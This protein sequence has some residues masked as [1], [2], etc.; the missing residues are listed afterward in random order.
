[1]SSLSREQ[2]YQVMALADGELEGRERA[3]AELLVASNAE[4]RAVLDEMRSG[5]LAPWLA[6]LHDGEE[7][8]PA[9]GGASLADP[10]MARVG[11]LAP[12]GAP[13]ASLDEARSR[14]APRVVALAFAAVAL[15]AGFAV[16]MRS[17]GG[18]TAPAP[19]ASAP[20]P[21]DTLGASALATMSSVEVNEVDVPSRGVSLFEIPVAGAAPSKR[22]SSV[23]VWIEDEPESP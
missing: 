23:V 20:S 5:R 1:M 18:G 8:R 6:A 3:Q 14:R 17:T 7:D 19:V 22:A 10:V 4:A 2:M 15:A 9:A 11:A 13:V 21:V 16:V 12:G